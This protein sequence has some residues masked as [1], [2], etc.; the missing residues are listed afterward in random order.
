MSLVS[1]GSIPRLHFTDLTRELEPELGLMSGGLQRWFGG[2]LSGSW[3]EAWLGEG[4]GEV[5]GRG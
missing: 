1:S 5:E 4:G 3:K 2:V